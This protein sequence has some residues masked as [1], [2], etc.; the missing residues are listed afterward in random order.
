MTTLLK[1]ER[2]EH[3]KNVLDLNAIF[4]FSQKWK[5]FKLVGTLIAFGLFGVTL[6]ALIL[7][8]VVPPTLR[9]FIGL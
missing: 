3:Y 7:A 1:R 2:L 8:T 5:K 6:E 4:F 9:G